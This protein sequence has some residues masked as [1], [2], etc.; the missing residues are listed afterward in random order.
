VTTGC[1]YTVDEGQLIVLVLD[2][3]HRSA[4]PRGVPLDLCLRAYA[5]GGGAALGQM[6]A[7]GGARSVLVISNG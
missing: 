1:S 3:G 6:S 7:G 4:H 5:A 2:A